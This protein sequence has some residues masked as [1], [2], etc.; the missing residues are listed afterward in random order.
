[1]A[2]VDVTCCLAKNQNVCSHKQISLGELFGHR[3]FIVYFKSNYLCHVHLEAIL[4][5][6]PSVRH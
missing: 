3:G 5:Q 6:L 2:D 1:L 4:Q